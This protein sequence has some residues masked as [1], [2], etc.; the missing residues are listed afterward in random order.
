MKNVQLKMFSSRQYIRV[1][2]SHVLQVNVQL[3]IFYFLNIIIDV[4]TIYRQIHCIWVEWVLVLII[5]I[6]HCICV[7]NY[8]LLVISLNELFFS[9][10]SLDGFK[11][12]MHS[13]FEMLNIYKS[14]QYYIY[15]HNFFSLTHVGLR[16]HCSSS[17][18]SEVVVYLV[19]FS[20]HVIYM[21]P[22]L[23]EKYTFRKRLW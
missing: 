1:K 18:Y 3:N 10:I 20:T 4:K 11:N 12:C 2:D 21:F 5:F 8:L 22:S 9:L 16:T 23:I 17:L 19:Y 15:K 14:T 13:I 7:R 6:S